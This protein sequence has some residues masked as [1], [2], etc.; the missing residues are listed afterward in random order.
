M[1]LCE[2]FGESD[3]YG[4]RFFIV[5]WYQTFSQSQ[6]HQ[7]VAE[8]IYRCGQAFFRDLDMFVAEKTSHGHTVHVL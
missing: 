7:P 2:P 3:K 6:E 4:R 1:Y 8:G 5:E